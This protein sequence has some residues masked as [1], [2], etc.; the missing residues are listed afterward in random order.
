MADSVS[1]AYLDSIRRRFRNYKELGE[2]AMAQV[3]DEDLY[4]LS[5]H[6]SNSVRLNVKH[7]SG[8]MRSRWTDVFTTDGEK[9]DRN[10]DDEFV[11]AGFET[12][13]ELMAHWE[14]GWACLLDAMDSFEPDDLLK[15]VTIRGQQIPL[16]DAIN[17][18]AMHV[19]YHVGQ[20]VHICRERAGDRWQSLSIARGESGQYKSKPTD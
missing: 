7:L 9:P 16:M 14:A 10:R 2:R 15:L 1:E 8:N 13:E 17:R 12:R 5:V 4:W 19:P 20:I 6:E 11:E 18:Q 3:E